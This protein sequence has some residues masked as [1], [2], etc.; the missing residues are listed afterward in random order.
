MH[1]YGVI[2]DGR[3]I[4]LGE[5]TTSQGPDGV[6][7]GEWV[8]LYPAC[9][10][11]GRR[12]PGGRCYACGLVSCAACNILCDQC[13][14]SHCKGDATQLGGEPERY[15]CKRCARISARRE[16]IAWL[17]KLPFRFF[18]ELRADADDERVKG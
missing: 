6:E 5:N 17:F 15:R 18:V 10:H 8:A 3:K 13:L 9:L 12:E 4:A 1:R 14:R 2:H 11:A 16:L 7:E